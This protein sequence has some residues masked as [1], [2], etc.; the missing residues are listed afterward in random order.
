MKRW[1][2]SLG[3][4]QPIDAEDQRPTQQ[5]GAQPRRIALVGRRLRFCADLVDVHADRVHAGLHRAPERGK[6]DHPPG[7]A[8]RLSHHIVGERGAVVFGLEA[9]QIELAHRADQLRVRRVGH[10]HRRRRE[11][12]VQKQADAVAQPG[13]A[14]R[15]GQAEQMVVVRPHQIVRP[16][17]SG[18]RLRE[19][20]VHPPIAVEL[21]PVEV[22]M[23]DLIVQ[24]RPQRAV[25]KAPVELVIVRVG[26][27]DRV[28]CDLARRSAQ[29]AALPPHR[30]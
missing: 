6:R 26:Q 3:I 29:R 20:R 10:E 13:I 11:R 4:V 18:E 25:G 30:R 17:Q 12:R 5:A 19:Q 16:H 9:K 21:R 8:A 1:P 24:R 15:L 14:Q 2:Q 28:K 23:V 27:I 7:N 22:G